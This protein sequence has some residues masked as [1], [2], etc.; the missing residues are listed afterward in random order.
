MLWNGTQRCCMLNPQMLVTEEQQVLPEGCGRLHLVAVP[1]VLQEQSALLMPWP[2]R[3]PLSHHK[4]V[5][6]RCRLQSRLD[7]E[8]K[9]WLHT[10]SM[11]AHWGAGLHG[12]HVAC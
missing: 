9:V 8:H 12:Q 1:P 11:P 5:R 3:W 6:R 4:R 10:T 2:P 7:A